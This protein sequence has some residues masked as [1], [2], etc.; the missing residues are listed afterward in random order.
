MTVAQLIKR[1]KVHDPKAR[2]ILPGDKGTWASATY[3]ALK[4][5]VPSNGG[6]TPP[7]TSNPNT[8]NTVLIA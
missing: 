6:Y 5:A 2:V 3:V 7:E 4:P 8:I 1:L